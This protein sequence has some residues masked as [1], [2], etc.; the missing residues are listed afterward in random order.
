MLPIIHLRPLLP[1][2]SGILTAA[3]H[4]FLLLDSLSATPQTPHH[5]FGMIVFM[6]KFF[7]ELIMLF[8]V[9]WVAGHLL[10]IDGFRYHK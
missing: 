1:I 3:M 8:G 7:G 4:T 10:K 5:T 2:T 6:P 9:G